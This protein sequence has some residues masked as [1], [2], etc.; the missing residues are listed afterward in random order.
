MSLRRPKTERSATRRPTGCTTSAPGRTRSSHSRSPCSG[1][2]PVRP[3]LPLPGPFAASHRRS[4]PPRPE[5]A[6]RGALPLR[7]GFA[8]SRPHRL[9]FVRRFALDAH[10]C[11][12]RHPHPIPPTPTDASRCGSGCRVYHNGVDRVRAHCVCVCVCALSGL[13]A[14]SCKFFAHNFKVNAGNFKGSW[15]KRCARHFCPGALS[16]WRSRTGSAKPC[17]CTLSNCLA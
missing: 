13:N 8:G 2:S 3:P 12:R 7:A 14:I 17:G 10:Y 9:V 16:F 1:C 11:P 5:Q 6:K 4:C 15:A